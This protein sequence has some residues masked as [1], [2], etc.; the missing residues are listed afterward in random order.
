[1]DSRETVK[2]QQRGP[3][4]RLRPT[5]RIQRQDEFR[6]VLRGGRVFRDP[7][8]RIHFLASG[9]ELSRLGLVVSRK[10]GNA[11]ARNLLKRRL[12]AIFRRVKWRFRTPLDLVLV[13]NPRSGILESGSYAA[14]MDR[15]ISWHVANI[16]GPKQAK[17]GG[18]S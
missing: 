16:T 5:E 3:D 9:R 15:F 4:L 13:P 14:V 12:R 1:M 11:V 7:I 10:S 6:R 17:P 8:L 18:R 2:A